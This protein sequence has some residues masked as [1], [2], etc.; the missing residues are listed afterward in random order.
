MAVEEF[1]DMKE[2]KAAIAREGKYLEFLYK[3]VK[4]PASEDDQLYASAKK[5]FDIGLTQKE[6]GQ[7][8]R[9]VGDRQQYAQW[10]VMA[11]V[12]SQ[13]VHDYYAEAFIAHYLLKDACEHGV[14][15]EEAKNIFQRKN[16]SMIQICVNHYEGGTEILTDYFSNIINKDGDMAGAGLQILVSSWQQLGL[17]ATATSTV[18]HADKSVSATP[19]VLC[20]TGEHAFEIYAWMAKAEKEPAAGAEKGFET[21]MTVYSYEAA[22]KRYMPSFRSAIR[23]WQPDVVTLVQAVSVDGKALI[24]PEVNIGQFER[25]PYP[26]SVFRDIEDNLPGIEEL[27]VRA[28]AETTKKD[29]ASIAKIKADIERKKGVAKTEAVKAL[30]EK[31][32]VQLN[33]T[34]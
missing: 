2:V 20:R 9:T 10:P 33:S 22:V 4:A 25:K 6:F 11:F 26:E 27:A 14:Y 29:S 34:K 23:E 16:S 3:N 24:C 1:F 13:Q 32:S 15:R 12:R 18:I 17:P 7:L 19:G 31:L 5:D 28:A 8:R 30:Y 21:F